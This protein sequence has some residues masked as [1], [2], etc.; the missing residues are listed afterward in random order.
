MQ[1]NPMTAST[2]ED[3][4][5]GRIGELLPDLCPAERPELLGVM[6]PDDMSTMLAWIATVYPLVFDFAIVRDRA[7]AG[8]LVTRLAEDEDDVEPYCRGCGASIGIFYGHGDAWLHF[9]GEGTPDNPVQLH[10]A[11]HAPVV[12]WRPAGAL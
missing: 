1:D 12:A 8:R 7:L 9:T 4:L 3:Q 11:D 2:H 10:D 6:D 5:A